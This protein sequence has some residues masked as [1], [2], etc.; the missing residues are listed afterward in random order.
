MDYIDEIDLLNDQLRE[1]DKQISELQQII[2]NLTEAQKND[3]ECI[4]VES[5]QKLGFWERHITLSYMALCVVIMFGIIVIVS[6]LLWPL[7]WKGFGCSMQ[8]TY[9]YAALVSIGLGIIA[10]MNTP[11]GRHWLKTL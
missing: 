2:C 3:T 1:K 7:W 5:E 9:T 4:D 8:L 11:R 10:W 6:P